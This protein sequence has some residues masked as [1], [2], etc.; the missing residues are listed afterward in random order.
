MVELHDL[1]HR[2]GLFDQETVE[3]RV[4]NYYWQYFRGFE[5]GGGEGG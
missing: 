5:P 1:R 2:F 4:E 3:R